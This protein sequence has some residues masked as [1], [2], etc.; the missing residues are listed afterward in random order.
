MTVKN[1]QKK[2]REKETGMG[3]DSNLND[4]CG[5]S[6][7]TI[8]DHLLMMFCNKTHLCIMCHQ[9]HTTQL[10]RPKCIYYTHIQAFC[11]SQG[12]HNAIERQF[13]VKQYWTWQQLPL[14][15]TF[16]ASCSSPKSLSFDSF[17][18]LSLFVSPLFLLCGVTGHFI[19]N[20][21]HKEQFQ[22]KAPKALRR[23]V[24]S[25]VY[26][27]PQNRL[28]PWWVKQPQTRNPS[29]LIKSRA[30]NKWQVFSGEDQREKSSPSAGTDRWTVRCA[31]CLMPYNPRCH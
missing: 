4:S 26:T 16:P 7:S 13:L 11:L 9:I 21:S 12:T 2:C 18:C 1:R 17:L 25:W 3:S 23:Q 24:G 29:L 19:C 28:L 6:G 22:E 8:W 30:A 31:A 27:R 15:Y 14:H 20:D 5:S 10:S